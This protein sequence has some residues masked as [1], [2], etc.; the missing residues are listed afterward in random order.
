MIDQ[1]NKEAITVFIGG[2]IGAFLKDILSDGCIEL[3][4]FTEKKLNLGFIGGWLIGGFA[5]FFIDGSFVTAAMAGYTGSSI[6]QNIMAQSTTPNPVQTTTY[7]Q[8]QTTTEISIPDLITKIC[9]EEEVDPNLALKVAKCESGLR[10]NAKNINAPDSIDRGLY[11]IN[12]KW[13]PEVTDEQAYNP[14]FS[15]RFFCQAVKANKLDMWDASKT[16]WNK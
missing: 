6:I 7:T 2:I 12:S 16:C 10:P 8:T 5:G 3:P 9:Q 4:Y 1:F 11:Q 15:I 13:H 14:E